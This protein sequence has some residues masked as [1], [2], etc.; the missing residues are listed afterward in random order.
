MLR[1]TSRNTIPVLVVFD[2]LRFSRVLNL[3][4]LQDAKREFNNAIQS[5][6]NRSLKAKKK[7]QG[8]DSM[9]KAREKAKFECRNEAFNSLNMISSIFFLFFFF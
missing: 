2:F 3:Q 8:F 5:I 4:S 6:T 1:N 7:G 9:G